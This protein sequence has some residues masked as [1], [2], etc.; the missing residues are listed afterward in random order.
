M[1][2]HYTLREIQ[3]LAGDSEPNR[4]RI[5]LMFAET[6]EQRARLVEDAIDHIA[7]EFGETPHHRKDRDEDGITIDVVS[8]LKMMGFRA[9]HDED[10]GGHCDIVVR[11]RDNFLWAAEAKIHSRYGWLEKGTKQI[12]DR[13]ST[14]VPGQDAGGLV[15]YVKVANTKAVME[16]WRKHFVEA[17][18]H[19]STV[20]CER[21]PLALVSTFTHPRSGLPF[22]LRHVP[23]SFYHHPTDSL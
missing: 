14:G 13:Y 7:I 17:F 6:N 10:I 18:P 16:T 5:G 15:V 12:I 1:S 3:A 9:T 22:R 8:S 11:D 23:I 20:Q 21:N 4:I 2:E 19:A